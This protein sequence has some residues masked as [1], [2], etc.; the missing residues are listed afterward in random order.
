[1]PSML[2]N[3]LLRSCLFDQACTATHTAATLTKYVSTTTD[4]ISK[5][6]G[7]LSAGA[8]SDQSNAASSRGPLH[9]QEHMR[10]LMQDAIHIYRSEGAAAVLPDRITDVFMSAYSKL[11]TT[12]QQLTFFTLLAQEFGVQGRSWRI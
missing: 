11:Q 9:T 5:W 7:L 2:L 6:Q 8:V 4:I 12:Q 1:M 3:R 10:Q